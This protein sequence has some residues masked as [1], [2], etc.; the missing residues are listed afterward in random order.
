MPAPLSSCGGGLGVG[1]L[2]TPAPTVQLISNCV[3]AVSFVSPLR[4]TVNLHTHF[5]CVRNGTVDNVWAIAGRGP[6]V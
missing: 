2:S 1:S 6:G 3:H 4:R 5:A